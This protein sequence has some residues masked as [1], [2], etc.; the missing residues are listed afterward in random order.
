MP[1]GR[2]L[3]LGFAALCAL[4]LVVTTL[5]ALSARNLQGVNDRI[6]GLRLPVAETSARMETQVQASLAALRGFLLTGQDRFR[7]DRAEAWR[8]LAE[9]STAME[10]LAARFTNQRNT[11]R[12]TEL[13]ALL[14]QISQFQEQ[15]EAAGPGEAGTTILVKELVPRV[16]RVLTIL[17][18]E[19]GADNRRS[20]G[21]VDSQKE[22]L[23]QDSAEANAL[24][25]TLQITAWAALIGGLGAGVLIAW[26]TRR[27]IVP[28]LAAI[29]GAMG[30]LA[31][32]DSTV[33]VPG[34]DRKDEIG[35][36]AHALEIFRRNLMQ[37]RELEARERAE[38]E[39]RNRRAALVQQLTAA[40][41]EQAGGLVNLVAG[42]ATEL[43]ATAGSMSAAA[44]QTA[45]QAAA[46]AAAS[47]QASANVQMVAA[48]AEEL[49]ASI[50]EISRQVGQSSSMAEGAV[51]E[52][53]RAAGEV[54]HL[55]EAVGRIGTVV[56]LISEIASQTN[57]LALNA[58]IEAA[59]AGE[60]GKGF[61]VV[62]NE[63]KGLANQT[64]KA[65]EEIGQ[66]ITLVQDQTRTVVDTIEAIVGV[67]HGLGTI[68][69]DISAAVGEQTSATGE[70]ARS[71]DEASIGS[72][73]V[74]A[75]ITGVRQAATSTGAASAQV[76]CASGDLATQARDL[77]HVLVDFLDRVRAA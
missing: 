10:P 35:A 49:S 5:A 65:T 19:R 18:G 24:L 63:V 55:A 60:A 17:A 22:L 33:A 4:L 45:S 64:A 54:G 32:G 36:M 47:D 51:T 73:E 21:M 27:S 58:T 74:Q 76:L 46:A 6:V 71:V 15:A 28:P 31:E 1:I 20:G 68:A 62:A 66:Q 13:K 52:A 3:S 30:R 72:G 38:M 23:A 59:R 39:A 61:A 77:R 43:E 26:A 75:N 37:Q 16:T 50:T 40:F 14:P 9:L 42:A 70:I 7:T 2:R 34:A 12:W 53:N 29:T 41:D 56:R 8:N 11:E 67:I 25:N 69:A 57:L 44:V 48:A